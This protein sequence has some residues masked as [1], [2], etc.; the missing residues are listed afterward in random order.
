M[1]PQ[2]ASHREREELSGRQANGI[3]MVPG[4]R[5]KGSEVHLTKGK[6]RRGWGGRGCER[7]S[8]ECQKPLEFESRIGV[9]AHLLPGVAGRTNTSKGHRVDRGLFWVMLVHDIQKVVAVQHHEGLPL[10]ILYLRTAGRF[11][12]EKQENKKPVV[13]TVSGRKREKSETFGPRCKREWVKWGG[14]RVG[15][16]PLSVSMRVSDG[17]A[18]APP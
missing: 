17:T 7:W 8:A 1:L 13:V 18:Y 15:C 9:R 4:H 14:A 10:G 12:N 2:V 16:S 3:V 5:R 11:K 6:E